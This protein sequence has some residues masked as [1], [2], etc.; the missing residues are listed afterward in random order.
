MKK[1]YL[2]LVFTLI[3]LS[4]CEGS[5]S[6]QGKWKALNSKGERFEITFTPKTFLI[7]SST[8][9]SQKYNY[10]QNSIKSENSIETY[11]IRVEEGEGYEIF[12]PFED[13]SIGL[14][15]DE[16]GVPI[17]TISRK[18]YITYDELYKLN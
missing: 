3:L 1:I 18:N 17:F 13:E 2:L 7:K 15:R 8:G 9:K 6:Y 4:S 10:T 14:I 16:N 12:F 5:D 11:G